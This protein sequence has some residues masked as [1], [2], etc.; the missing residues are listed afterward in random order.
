MFINTRKE[1]TAAAAIAS[2]FGFE[3]LTA[4]KFYRRYATNVFAPWATEN[5][6]RAAEA[7]IAK[8]VREMRAR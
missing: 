1:A 4:E 8:R 6:A 5:A 2:K 3:T 7:A